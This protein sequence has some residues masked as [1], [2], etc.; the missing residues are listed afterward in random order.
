MNK[1]ALIADIETKGNINDRYEDLTCM[2]F[3]SISGE[4]IGVLSLVFNGKDILLDKPVAIKFMDPD[5]LSDDYRVDCF[6]R[7]PEI[8]KLLEGKRRCLQ[9]VADIATHDLVQKFSGMPPI[10]LP[11]KFFVLDSENS[12]DT[13]RILGTPY[14]IQRN[15]LCSIPVTE[16]SMQK[17]ANWPPLLFLEIGKYAQYLH[18]C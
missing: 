16:Y 8:L 9:L 12:G 6:H 5:Q 14:L 18:Y 3:D 4:R 11:C 10:K 13:W 7:E 17:A 15:P 2:N 1:R